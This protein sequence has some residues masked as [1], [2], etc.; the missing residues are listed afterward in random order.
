[1]TDDGHNVVETDDPLGDGSGLFP[2][3]LVVKGYDDCL[4]TQ[5]AALS[6]PLISHQLACV[7]KTMSVFGV[8]PGHSSS[9]SNF[10]G[11]AFIQVCAN[12]S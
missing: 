7:D 5:N 4:A 9:H 12:D 2:R 6:I 8:F 3:V 10:D 11:V 1:M